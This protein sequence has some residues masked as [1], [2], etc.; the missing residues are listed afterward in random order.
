[1]TEDQLIESVLKGDEE[2][3]R[4]YYFTYKAKLLRFV[5][6]RVNTSEDAEEILQ[7]TFVASLESLRDFTGKSALYTFLCS[8]AKHKVIDFYRKK[9]IKAI[10]FSQIP[11]NIRPLVSTLLK[12]E[13]E[14]DLMELKLQVK[15]V[16]AVIKPIYSQVLRLKYLEGFSVLEIAKKL[17]LSVKSIESL[18]VRARKA[19]AAQYSLLYS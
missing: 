19:F 11:E 5:Q 9:K 3:L 2:A 10:V 7:D 18:L 16:L 8:I 17:V 14:F 12:P 15:R 4:V 13:D 6:T 1:M